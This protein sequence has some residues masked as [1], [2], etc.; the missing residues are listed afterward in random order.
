MVLSYKL[1][2]VT[3]MQRPGLT[4]DQHGTNIC[5]DGKILMRGM[6]INYLNCVNFVVK[7][8]QPV[9]QTCNSDGAK[10]IIY[11]INGYA[12]LVNKSFRAE[13]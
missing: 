11:G 6:A 8:N 12:I 10:Y 9:S 13:K 3:K 1:L 2:S 5:K 4:F 7:V